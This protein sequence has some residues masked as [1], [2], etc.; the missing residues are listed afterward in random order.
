MS[1]DLVFFSFPLVLLFDFFFFSFSLPFF[2]FDFFS[3]FVFSF[4][5]FSLRGEGEGDSE[6]EDE[7]E[8]ED[9]R[10]F[11]SDFPLWFSSDLGCSKIAGGVIFGR[12]GWP[13]FFFS[14]S[15]AAGGRGPKTAGFSLAAFKAAAGTGRGFLTTF[16]AGRKAFFLAAPAD[17]STEG[18]SEEGAG[19]ET[20]GIEGID[21]TDELG[22]SNF[23]AKAEAAR[24]G[25]EGEKGEAILVD[26]SKMWACRE[27][28]PRRGILQSRQKKVCLK[29]EVI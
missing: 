26:C 29:W 19:G 15:S 23:T 10:D 27:S 14:L 21:G 18:I 8:A 9:E 20:A 12:T 11:V 13:V 6:R 17:A 3:F 16:G 7:E 24:F 22:A 4:L 2:D 5:V 25:S 1:L 28:L